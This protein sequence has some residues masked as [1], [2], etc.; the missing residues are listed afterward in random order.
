MTPNQITAARMVAAFLSVAL[1]VF[2][3]RDLAAAIGALI[4]TVT[5]FSLDAVDGYIAR[6]R[7]MATPLGAQFDILGDRVIEN[8]YLTFFA[9][10][11]TISVWVPV[12]FFV[13]GALADL[14]RGLAARKG[15]SGFGKKS[16]HETRLA[17]VLVASRASRFTYAALKCICFV[18]LGAVLTITR[19]ASWLVPALALRWLQAAA[20]VFVGLTVAFCVIRFLPVGWEGRRYLLD[21]RGAPIHRPARAMRQ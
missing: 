4:L 9:T 8:L 5:A 2:C 19:A 20:Q 14:I 7:G 21:A 6:S 10:A 12:I 3:P 11:G 1:F 13:R 18:Y 17:R 16:M 15:R